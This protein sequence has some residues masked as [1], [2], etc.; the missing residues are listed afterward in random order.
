MEEEAKMPLLVASTRTEKKD[1][2]LLTD[3]RDAVAS[4]RSDFFSKLPEKP[5]NSCSKTLN[6][7]IEFSAIKSHSSKSKKKKKILNY[8]SVLATGEPDEDRVL[9]LVVALVIEMHKCPLDFSNEGPLNYLDGV[10]DSECVSTD[11]VNSFDLRIMPQDEV[12]FEVLVQTVEQLIRDKSAPAEVLQKLTY[13]V[14][15]HD[16]QDEVITHPE[17]FTSSSGTYIHSSIQ[18]LPENIELS[19]DMPLKEAH[20]IGESLQIKIEE[21]PEVERAFVHLDYECEHKPEH[22]VLIRLPSSQH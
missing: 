18:L 9:R 17:S 3:D 21:L 6:I 4:L 8:P 15:R 20:T 13:L 2:S 22:S 1:H 5:R 12:C 11:C 14:L 7:T 16:P 10:K 19:K